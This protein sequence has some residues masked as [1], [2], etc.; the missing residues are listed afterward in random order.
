V[1]VYDWFTEGLKTPVFKEAKA[2]LDD[3]AGAH[4]S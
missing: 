1:P 3:L 4:E 2:L